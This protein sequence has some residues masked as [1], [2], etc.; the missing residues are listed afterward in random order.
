M[1]ISLPSSP[2]HSGES[3][4]V[5]MYAHTVGL[6]LTAWRVRLY[7]S[8]SHPQ[9]SSFEQNR[10]FNSASS[11]V[12]TGEVSWLATGIKSTTSNAQVTGTAIYLLHTT[13][14]I[15][16][17][18]VAGVY[19]GSTLGLY[20]R[21]TELI[22]GAAFVQ[23]ADGMVF[24][25]RDSVQTRGQLVVVASKTA[26]IFVSAPGGVLAN[27]APL[28]GAST[29]YVVTTVQVSDDERYTSDTSVVSSGVSCSTS[30][31][32]I[33]VSLDGCSV[34]LGASHSV[35]AAGVS[36]VVRFGSFSAT[37]LFDVY[38]PQA[39]SLS[40][41]D[42]TLNRFTANGGDSI[43][44][45]CTSGGTAAYPYQRTRA[46]AYADGLDATPLVTFVAA[47]VSV[48]DVSSASSDVIEGKRAG[49]TTVHLG[50]RS[51]I[52]PSASLT[53]SDV[54]VF[55]SSL[56]AR[57]VTAVEWDAGG[58]PS[59]QYAPGDLVAASIKVSRR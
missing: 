33:V 20:P 59:S 8:R 18:V 58:Q 45:S 37:A 48:A 43:A 19:E 56:V 4:S 23:D 47:D 17:G 11:S 52:S 39:T 25:G 38:T 40:L 36:V 42:S 28:T 12:S 50:G 7:F 1:F 10:H 51:G 57:L 24:D 49:S 32:S 29:N 3:F 13:L 15:A 44:S 41:L 6:S 21:A 26:G 46:V 54:T 30:A 5:Y 55:A 14:T 9:Y 27:L 31:A 53:V 16:S 34:L 35:S 2:L 22:S